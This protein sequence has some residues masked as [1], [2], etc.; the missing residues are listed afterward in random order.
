VCSAVRRFLQLG[1][2]LTW[3]SAKCR[4]TRESQI[5][6][7]RRCHVK[8]V[9]HPLLVCSHRSIKTTQSLEDVRIREASHRSRLSGSVRAT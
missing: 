7:C 5:G 9:S 3:P 6:S 4:Q 8:R 1:Y 2:E